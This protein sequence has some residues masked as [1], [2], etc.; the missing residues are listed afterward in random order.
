MKNS[1]LHTCPL[2]GGR[3]GDALNHLLVGVAIPFHDE[4]VIMNSYLL[5]STVLAHSII[6]NS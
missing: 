3:A 4:L 1:Q 6:V 5:T 2:S